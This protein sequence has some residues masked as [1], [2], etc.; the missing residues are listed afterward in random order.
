MAI[1]S[2]KD[3]K[4]VNSNKIKVLIGKGEFFQDLISLTVWDDLNKEYSIKELFEKIF[5]LENKNL[6]LEQKNQEL[7]ASL[8]QYIQAQ[9]ATDGLI[10]KAADLLSIKVAQLESEVADL[11]DKTKFL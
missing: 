5:E 2:K 3:S 7:K 11:K 4:D 6:E 10:V 8:K 1:R 9:K